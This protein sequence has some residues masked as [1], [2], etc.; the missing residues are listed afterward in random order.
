MDQ[1]LLWKIKMLRFVPEEK[2]TKN[3]VILHLGICR[4]MHKGI[5]P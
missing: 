1:F 3:V 2:N 5:T 4:N